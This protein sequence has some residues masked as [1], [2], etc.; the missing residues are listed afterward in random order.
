MVKGNQ[1]PDATTRASLAILLSSPGVTQMHK[2]PRPEVRSWATKSWA[3]RAMVMVMV[4]VM[5]SHMVGPIPW[6]P[7]SSRGI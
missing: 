3:I 7:M 2:M 5:G 1:L 4:M 6:I